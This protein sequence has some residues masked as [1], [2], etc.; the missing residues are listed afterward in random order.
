MPYG[1]SLVLLLLTPPAG[2]L[3]LPVQEEATAVVAF[4]N[5]R[6]FDGEEFLLGTRYVAGGVFHREPPRAVAQ[7]I[8][9]G[10]QWVVP[11]YGDAHTHLLEPDVIEQ[12]VA[13]LLRRGV[14]YVRD[15]NSALSIRAR[16]E[17][18]LARSDTFD[19]VSP[20]QGFTG[21]GGHPI[22]IL[23][24]L[25]GLGSFPGDWTRE[26][27][28]A[29]SLFV[30]ESLADVDAAWPGYLA[31]EP[32]FVKLFLVYSELHAERSGHPDHLYACGLDPALAAP[33][34]ERAHAAG[35]EVS[36]HVYTRADFRTAIDAG[37][38]LIAHFPGVG[39]DAGLG[40]AHFLLTE[41][42]AALA[43]ER[44][45]SVITTLSDM[46]GW[47]TPIGAGTRAFVD[48]VIVPN[49]DLLLTAGVPI[50]IGSDRIRTTSDVEAEVL[51]ELELFDPLTLLE[52][53]C[54]E[55]P[56]SIFPERRIGRLADGYEASFL[57]LEGDPLADFANTQRIALRVKQGRLLFPP[58][59][60]FPPLG[61]PG[62]PGAPGR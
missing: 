23:L 4:E 46:L 27:L 2:P 22:Q 1:S 10:G 3:P 34:V 7:T 44:G 20:N 35:L 18:L 6:W 21:P 28:F 33:L 61:V 14:F 60:E 52:M 49:L 15:Q 57:V 55:T 36:A 19:F 13:L 53:W 17:P 39:Y 40:D 9:L 56:Q 8:D 45:V 50:L 48:R 54:V 12:Y 26:Q 58:V 32:D 47:P 29:D 42:D 37:V 30:V 5:G 24:Q 31:G 11:P 59:P 16:I 51:A 38:D 41:E 43:G 25:Q 62:T